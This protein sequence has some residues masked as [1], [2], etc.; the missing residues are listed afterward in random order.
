MSEI[1]RKLHLLATDLENNGFIIQASEVDNIFI[2]VAAKKKKNKS[3]KNVP[4]NPS[5]WASCK[6]WA[7]ST[8]DVYPC[9]PLDSLALTKK[10]WAE[11]SDLNIGDEILS[12]NQS[13]DKLEWKPVV[14]L[15]FYEDAPTLSLKKLQT[16][17]KVRCTPDHKWVLKTPNVKYPDNLV[18][19]KNITKRM[20]LKT[21]AEIVDD[22]NENLNLSNWRKGDDWVENI[23]KMS[24][25]Q[26]EA[27]FAA[28]I[29]YDGN[30]KGL[31]SLNRS[32]YGFS[33]KNINHGEAMEIAAVLLGY[34]VSFV[35]KMHNAE[36]KSWTFIKR[37]SESTGN[38]IIEEDLNCDVWCPETENNTWVM[39]QGRIITITGNSAYANGAAA[40]RYKSKGGTWRKAD[41]DLNKRLA[42]LN[43]F[44]MNDGQSDVPKTKTPDTTDTTEDLTDDEV[45]SLANEIRTL[46]EEADTELRQHNYSRVSEIISEIETIQ[47]QNPEVAALAKT[48]L[49][50]LRTFLNLGREKYPDEDTAEP[51]V[52]KEMPLKDALEEVKEIIFTKGEYDKAIKFVKDVKLTDGSKEYLSKMLDILIVAKKANPGAKMDMYNDANQFLYLAKQKAQRSDP[53]ANLGF[54]NIGK[55][56]ELIYNYLRKMIQEEPINTLY[57]QNVYKLAL[58][59]ARL[60]SKI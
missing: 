40:K 50:R 9:V 27:F 14:N 6:A 19:A 37:D 16:N 47:N 49:D 32:T 33:Q 42:Q 15:H 20:N 4:N 2:K 39:K 11:Y 43:Q 28:G 17:F 45:L 34:R 25:A 7:K 51:D 56:D 54:Q 10:G 5:L 58:E 57:Y 12:Y 59:L 24:K 52:I 55:T 29:V 44:D 18:E 1:L 41:S 23:L 8:F 35:Q 3:G 38:L 21:A 13:K 26:L 30:D 31:S 46:D 22:V 53:S 60:K 48:V 36:M